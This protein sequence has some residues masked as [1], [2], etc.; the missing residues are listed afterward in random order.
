M[1]LKPKQIIWISIGLATLVVGIG[2]YMFRGKILSY[3]QESYIKDLNKKVRSK[4]RLLINRIQKETGYKM[5]ITSGYRDFEHQQRLKNQN[6]K[7][8]KAGH[9]EHNYGIALDMIGIKGSHRLSKA[10]SK[11]EWESTGIPQIAKSMGFRWG[12]DFKNYHD[13]V[14][15]GLGNIYKTADLLQ[16]A[17]YKYG[18]S[19]KNIKGNEIILT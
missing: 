5:I 16:K 13:P 11:E 19:S 6:S 14:H 1:N 8:A 18:T 4:F 3:Q 12:G 10:S 15:F 7:N 17:H 9:S 2:L